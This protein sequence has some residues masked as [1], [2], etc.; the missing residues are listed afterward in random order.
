MERSIIFILAFSIC[1]YILYYKI[2]NYLLMYLF[3]NNLPRVIIVCG[4]KYNGKDTICDYLVEKYGYEKIALSLP[5][6]NVCKI[7]FNLTDEQ[8]YTN[9]KEII[10]DRY[11]VSPRQILQFVGTDMFR[12]KLEELIKNSSNTWLNPIIEKIIINKNK[13]YIICDGREQNE[14]DTVKNIESSYSIRVK[15]N[16]ESNYN[17]FHASE[18]NI[19]LLNNIDFEIIN[20]GLFDELYNKIDKIIKI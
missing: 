15:R 20:D 11:C 8:L 7:V 13:K 16:L 2:K 9:K 18:K 5:L 10:D 1:V 17:D 3:K 12:L 6:K 4:K 19:D 14:I